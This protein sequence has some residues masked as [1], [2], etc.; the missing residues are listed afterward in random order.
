MVSGA[1]DKEFLFLPVA[2]MI[3]EEYFRSDFND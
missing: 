2:I 3:E 1:K